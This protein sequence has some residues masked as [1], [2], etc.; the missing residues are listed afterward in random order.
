MYTKIHKLIEIVAHFSTNEWDFENKNTR[1][2]WSHLDAADKKLFPFSM[3]SFDWDTY[4]YNY[5]KGIRLY[6]LKGMSQS[7]QISRFNV[8]LFSFILLF[9]L[10]ILGTRYS[11]SFKEHLRTKI[12]TKIKELR[13][14]RE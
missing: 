2:L 4:I 10:K 3:Q 13:I 8:M 6:I 5:N 9:T 1:N 12:M 7:T 11:G 14:K